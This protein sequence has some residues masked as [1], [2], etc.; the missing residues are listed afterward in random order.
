M[1]SQKII[2]DEEDVIKELLSDRNRLRAALARIKVHLMVEEYEAA[3]S[4]TE[5]ALNES[6]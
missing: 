6:R 1:E 5:R 2:M 4:E 3:K